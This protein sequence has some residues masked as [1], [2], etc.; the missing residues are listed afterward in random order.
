MRTAGADARSTS[1]ADGAGA[2]G[3]RATTGWLRRGSRSSCCDLARTAGGPRALEHRRADVA[4][5]RGGCSS[6][7]TRPSDPAASTRSC[8]TACSTRPS[9]RR[10]RLP[11]PVHGISRLAVARPRRAGRAGSVRVAR[12]RADRRRARPA[13]SRRYGMATGGADRGD[14]PERRRHRRRRHLGR[15]P[16]GLRRDGPASCDFVLNA[17][18]AVDVGAAR[19]R[20]RGRRPDGPRAA[21]ARAS[22]SELADRT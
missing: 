18:S 10:P 20:H 9:T 4:R 11:R 14:G 12:N 17:C 5:V 21:P 3:R 1:A 2:A 19:R 7:A 16:S 6:G 22:A 8:P 15:A 13:G